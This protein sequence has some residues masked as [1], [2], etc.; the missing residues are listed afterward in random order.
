MPG[1]AA[2]KKGSESY[3][4]GEIYGRVYLIWGRSGIRVIWLFAMFEANI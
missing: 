1:K 3:V 2:I 4:A